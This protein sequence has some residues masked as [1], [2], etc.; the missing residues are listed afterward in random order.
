MNH[1]D[2][3]RDYFRAYKDKDRATL[4]RVLAPDLIHRSPFGVFEGRDSMLDQI[5]PS[6]GAVW[7]IDLEILGDAPRYM[8]RY[9]HSDGSPARF[10]EYF[11]FDG[12]RIAEID[13]YLGR[14][15]PGFS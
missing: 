13:V 9:R 10:A 5:W 14:G 3:I 1:K 2:A 11:F 6:V 15:C 12:D 8:V 4:E 7:A